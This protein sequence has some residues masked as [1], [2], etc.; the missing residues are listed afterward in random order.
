MNFFNKKSNTIDTVF[1]HI[2]KCG[3]SSV[4]EEL[5]RKEIK[6][7][8]KHV[9]EVKFRSKKK[10]YII[11]RNPIS[12]FVSAFNWRY[13]LVVEDGVQKDRF[14]GEKAFL[15]TYEN[16]NTLAESIYNEN[17]ELVLDFKKEEFYIHHI[18]ED[19]D[20][21]LGDV[22]KKCKKEHIIAVLATET[23][24]EDIKRHFDINLTSHLKKNKKSTHLSNLA[25]N[26]LVRYLKKDYDCI[27]RLNNMNLLTETQ[28]EKLSNRTFTS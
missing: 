19:I 2:G 15:E 25:I 6:F 14:E 26:N 24:S 3:G 20:F 7:I 5:K 11:I 8:E 9:A 4:I 23:L 28:Y 22:L 1:I 10:Y 18:K 27:E 12:R 13:K 21:Y 16:V 17:D